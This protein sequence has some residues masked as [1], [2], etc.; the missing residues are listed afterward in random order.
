MYRKSLILAGI[1][2]LSLFSC[3]S[4]VKESAVNKPDAILL[5]LTEEARFLS[6]DEVADRIINQDPALRLVDVRGP[7][8]FRVFTLPAAKNIPLENILES[9]ADEFLDCDRYDIVFFSNGSIH[10]EQAWMLRRRMGCERLYVLKG[11]LN[12]WA[13]KIL[14]PQEPGPA[15]AADEIALFQFR[16]GACQYFIGASTELEPEPY[17]QPV[18]NRPAPKTIPLKPKKKVVEEEEGC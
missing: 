9:E 18:V 11:G 12:D 14:S 2:V 16:K 8:Q 15:A 6:V 3:Q 17:V 4:A 1:I 10:A 5:E 13:A 7:E